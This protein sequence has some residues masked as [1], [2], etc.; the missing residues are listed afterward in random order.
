ML[1]IYI[2]GQM[3]GIPQY[4]YQEFMYAEQVL[5]DRGYM[6]INPV[7]MDKARGFD[8][9]TLPAST[10]WHS[11]PP[12]MDMQETAMHCARE[13]IS[14]DGIYMLKS[15]RFSK[16]AQAEHAIADWLGKVIL[17]QENIRGQV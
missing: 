8:L 7:R 5:R 4:N 9:L 13:V 1:K 2:A 15:W 17:Y 12:G 14:A 10:D 3:R 6:P 16:G 11:F